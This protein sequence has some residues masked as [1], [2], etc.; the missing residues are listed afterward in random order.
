MNKFLKCGSCKMI[1]DTTTGTMVLPG[2]T[3]ENKS[4]AQY[5]EA[6]RAASLF[7]CEACKFVAEHT[8]PS[9]PPDPATYKKLGQ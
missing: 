8:P 3:K 7:I 6:E 1:L 2:I 5:Q 9:T 4:V